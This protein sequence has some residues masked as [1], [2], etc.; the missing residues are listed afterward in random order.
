MICPKCGRNVPDGAVCPC[1]MG[2]PALSSNPALHVIKTVGSSGRFLAAAALMT[3]VPLLSIIGALFMQVDL[4]GL[5][6]YL[7]ELDIDPEVLYLIMANTSRTSLVSAVFATAPAILTAVALWLLYA[8]CRDRQ[9]GNISTAGLTICRVLA[10]L[11]II[12]YCLL[13]LLLVVVLVI[14][15][16]AAAAGGF[17]DLAYDSYG[18]TVLVTFCAVA[19]LVLAGVIALLICYQVCIVKTIGRI[20][21]TAMSGVPDNRVPGFLIG[22]NWFLG[23]CSCISGLFALFSSPVSGVASLLGAAATIL[24]AML[25][26][27]YRSSMTMLLYPPAP[28]VY[29]NQPVPPQHP[30]SPWR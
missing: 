30:G 24:F 7:Y 25:L 29:P 6:Y 2:A 5:L 12:L 10:I 9:S 16:I 15:L 21:A 26:S 11:S 17:D 13:A 27:Q 8:T 20:K 19:L 23:I 14:V 18:A 22:M 4:S 28:P 3:A 1:S